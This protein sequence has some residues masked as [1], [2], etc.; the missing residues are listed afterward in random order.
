MGYI[1][2]YKKILASQLEYPLNSTKKY[3]YSPWVTTSH[4]KSTSHAQ[5]SQTL[6]TNLS[7]ISSP[8]QLFFRSQRT[9]QNQKPHD[10]SFQTKHQ[11]TRR[12]QLGH[13]VGTSAKC[14]KNIELLGC[15]KGRSGGPCYHTTNVQSVDLTNGTD[16]NKCRPASRRTSIME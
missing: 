3:S 11:H 14:R 12:L 10:G 7:E 15:H 1:F 2:P 8:R 6:S 9:T 5:L 13:V 4:T 16:T